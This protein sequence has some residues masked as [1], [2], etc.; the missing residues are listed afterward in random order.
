MHNE[1]DLG[2]L[3]PLLAGLF[4]IME[5]LRVRNSDAPAI[6]RDGQLVGRC[7]LAAD[8]AVGVGADS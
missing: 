7:V 3:R 1:L 5:R 6:R 4:G 8:D 2:Q